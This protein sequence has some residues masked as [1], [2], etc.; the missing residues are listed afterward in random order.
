MRH[1]H[2][3]K[4]KCEFAG[5]SVESKIKDWDLAIE[6]GMVPV[7][8]LEE[9]NN[10]GYLSYQTPYGK[11]YITQK[12]HQEDRQIA[13]DLERPISVSEISKLFVIG[14]QKYSID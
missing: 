9:Y 11:G 7:E 12:G 4:G 2:G 6:R 10:G 3:E 8:K 13:I 14:N 5:P 1:F